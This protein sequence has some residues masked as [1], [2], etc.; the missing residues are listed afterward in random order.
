[1]FTPVLSPRRMRW[2]AIAGGSSIVAVAVVVFARDHWDGLYDDAFIYLRY[3]RNL[4]DGCGLRFNCGG[5]RVEGFTSPLFLALLWLGSLGTNQLIWLCQ[6]VGAASL[7]GAGAL[8]IATCAR[9]DEDQAGWASWLLPLACALAL[10]L[11]PFV[12]LNANIGLETATAAACCSCVGL[13][14]M[15]RRQALLTAAAIASF[16][17]RPEGVLFI[18]ALPLLPELRRA[19][20]LAPAAAA[21]VV[22]TLTRIALF[23]AALPN[24]YYAK[25]GGSWRYVELGA[26]YLLD[27]LRDFPLTFLAPLALLGPRRR[28]ALY[29]VVVACAWALFFLRIGGDTFA[30]SRLWLPLVPMLT[31]LALV[32]VHDGLKARLRF[33]AAVP[34]IVALV[35]GGRATITH[36]I[37]PQGAS[38]RIVEWAAVGAYLRAHYPHGTL[39]ATVPIGAIGYYSGLPILDLVGLTDATIARAGRG[40]PSEL[41]QKRW[42]GHERH[43][44]EYVLEREPAVIVTTMRRDRAWSLADAKAGF[45]ADWLL[46][47]EI[48]A[49][50]APYHVLDAE[51]MPG[52]H[53][54]MFERAAPKTTT[55]P[56]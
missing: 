26:T 28:E 44:L 53:V 4:D 56:M 47:Q 43:D 50:R 16:L 19:R 23:D 35:V 33:A 25:A 17:V 24:T 45:W 52:A 31:A 13:A 11:D 51:V 12:L 21:V 15:Q 49:G 6:I 5:A 48:K 8:A 10:A 42:I 27:C 41:L 18:V 40:V 55:P 9:S 32:G 2:L 1:M 39:V 54:L 22:V 34:M 38:S 29:L 36:A 30:Y 3:V 37:P 14:A 7:I 20:Y 46:L